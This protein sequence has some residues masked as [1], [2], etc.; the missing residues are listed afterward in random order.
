MAGTLDPETVSTRLR[1]IAELAKERPGEALRTL[2][3]HIDIDFL[4]EAYRRT[5]KDGAVGVDRQTAEKYAEDLES[6][7]RSLLER[8]KSGTYRAP[9]VRRVHIPK[10]GRGPAT[11]PIGVPTFEDKILQRAVAMVLEAVYE[12]DFLDCSFGFRPGRSAHRALEVLREGLMKMGGGHVLELDVR[13]FFDTLDHGQLGEILRKRVRDGVLLRLI[14]K[15]LHAGVMEEGEVSYPESGTPQGGCISPALAN[16][17]LHEV[18]DTWFEWTVKPRLKGRG[19]LIRYAD[20][21][22]LVF[23]CEEDARRVEAVLPKRFARYG[24][25]L[26]PEKTRLVAFHPPRGEPREG[27][28]GPQP[29]SFDMLGFT[30]YWS[31]SKRGWWVIK[32]KTARDRMTR[33]LQAIRLWCRRN[34]HAPVAEQHAALVQ[35]L[36]G[37]YGYYGIT[38]NSVAITRFRT[39]VRKIWRKWLDRRH[40][41]R[42]CHGLGS[43]CSRSATRSPR[44]SPSTRSTVAQRSHDL[45]S[46][47]R[48]SRTP[49]SVGAPGGRLPGATRPRAPAATRARR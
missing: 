22:V 11:R 10:G 30:H 49:G 37:H 4:R 27:E 35:K 6:N 19:F 2:A 44:R 1:R 28:D 23:S 46:R 32:R 48:S 12:Q 3:H 31:R 5:R 33:A 20:D 16:V 15:W 47:V 38:G 24:L 18:L 29:T 8:A 26:H 45:R 14:G 42:T 7:L 40:R 21:A 25:T 41:G 34:R 13:S 36:R 9:P 43:S 17:F 39:E